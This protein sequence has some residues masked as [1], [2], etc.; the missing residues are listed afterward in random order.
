MTWRRPNYAGGNANITHQDVGSLK[1]LDS[2]GCRSMLDVGCSTGDQVK[3]ALDLGWGAFGIDV[4]DH[5]I[6]EKKVPNC[7]LIDLAVNPVI[8]HKPFDV[9]WSVEVAEHIPEEFADKFVE[10]LVKNCDK[11]LILT[12]NNTPGV[13]HPNPQPLSY[14]IEKIEAQGLKHSDKLKENI[15][16][17][18]TMEREFLRVN[19]M[20]FET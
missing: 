14:W 3:N 19:G 2:I 16:E 4:D 8:F 12:A 13:Y 9:V 17:H 20:F 7:A 15:L 5:V 18:S 1:Y 6:F 10:T 11:Y